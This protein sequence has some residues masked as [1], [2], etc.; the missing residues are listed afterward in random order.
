MKYRVEIDGYIKTTQYAIIEAESEEKAIAIFNK[1]KLNYE[2]DFEDFEI[3]EQAE[4]IA[5]EEDEGQDEKTKT[6]D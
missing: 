3:A 5:S 2:Y 4:P 1:G 6:T